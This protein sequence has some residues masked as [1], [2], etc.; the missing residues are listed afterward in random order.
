MEISSY[1][2]SNENQ[3][4]MGIP[5]LQHVKFYDQLENKSYIDS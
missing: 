5:C 3:E 4:Q 1:L 2:V